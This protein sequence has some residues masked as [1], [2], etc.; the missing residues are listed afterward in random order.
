ME[1]ST[2]V[3]GKLF[4]FG[5]FEA[6]AAQ[7]A[8]TRNGAKI[9]IQEQ[10]FRLLLLLLARPNELIT[11]DELRQNLWAEGTYVDFD[12][13]LNVILKRLRAAI[14]DDPDNPR[15]I[16]TVPRQGYRFIAPVTVIDR[17]RETNAP[18]PMAANSPALAGVG[19][20]PQTQPATASGMP[21]SDRHS[22]PYVYVAMGLA[23]L[24]MISAGLLVWRYASTG[25]SASQS[26]LS[27]PQAVHM[28]KSVAVIGFHDLS[29]RAGNVWLGTALSEMLSTELAGGEKLRLVSGEDV[30][31][32][33]AA[34][35]WSQTDTLDR[36]TTARIG[37]ALNT[38]V[39]V[40]GSYVTIGSGDNEQLRLD[41]SMQDAKTGEIIGEVADVGN[42]K[43][44][45]QLVSRV[46]A[47]VRG[48]LGIGPLQN[49]DEAGVLAS[50]PVDPE[51]ARLYALGIEKL[52]QFDALAACDLLQQAADADPK[53]P[54]VHAMLA[55]AWALLGYEQKRRDEAK[56]ALDLSTDLP[57]PERMLVQGEYY[58]S[59][60]NQE[61]AASVYHALFE[62]FPDNLEYG[63]RL[64]AVQ[65]TLGH[66]S[67]A[68]EVIR[69]LR[70]LP[71]PSSD[72]PRIDLAETHA[73]E[74]NKPAE[75]VLIR[76]AMRK[77]QARGHRMLYALAR[78]EECMNL[79]YGGDA[80]AAEPSCEEAYNI[81]IS[82]GNRLDA[83]DAI[84]LMADKTG[85]A[86]HYEEAIATYQRAL[87][88]IEGLGEHHKTG[89][90]ENNMAIAYANEGK[91][92][93]SEQLYRQAKSDFEQAGDRPL[94]AV[95]MGNIADIL[96]LR[97]NLPAAAKLY[98]QTLDFMA[99][100]DHGEPGYVLMR[101]ADLQ[102]TQGN[103]RDAHRLAQQA[104][105]SLRP[106]E[107]A[108]QSQAD[109]MVELGSALE[110][111]GD[112]Q[113]AKEQ[114]EQTAVMRQ[115]FGASLL[116]E[117]SHVE[118]AGVRI[119]EGH[120]DDAEPLLR[121]AL[122]V[123]EKEKSDPD[124]SS[125]YTLLSRVLLEQGKLDDARSAAKKGAQLSLSSADPALRLPAEIQEA[126]VESASGDPGQVAAARQTL[127]AVIA[128]A[129]KLGYYN[130]ECE[131]R[132][133]LGELEL[134]ANPSIGHRQLTTLASETHERGLELLA[135]QAQSAIASGA[136]VARN[137]T[138]P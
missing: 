56:K 75:L 41:V 76:S 8:L 74:N 43:D 102:L 134:K 115:K 60:G 44:M 61:Q 99:T 125:A 4:R 54:L 96:Y 104:I 110:A 42:T 114:F 137:R 35:P 98:Q 78:K 97:G 108:F 112:L 136:A 36:S 101:L 105:D 5:V 34:S 64:A 126:R 77:A 3:P 119:E 124:S 129:A 37:E 130:V 19:L 133:A 118:L 29:G 65:T 1:R 68:S 15:F 33:R 71:L 53:F 9:K 58:E 131:A 48:I 127:H 91:L 120:P 27:S 117:E 32:L 24:V 132:L 38:D 7:G 88:V 80:A 69:R 95:T 47:R 81:F 87:N 20:V 111:E 79:L 85:S 46:G 10:P 23:A 45:F 14:N 93:R 51:A 123:F 128:T 107:N 13:S 12:G 62:L 106:A 59:I 100:V 49:A 113:G 103:V 11:R 94:V 72:D 39:L 2:E 109:A 6:D 92:D 31:N 57:R 50:L 40:L 63:L 83:A 55:R 67:Q 70:Q 135:H 25:A 90:I 138:T 21:I 17:V 52:R 26:F 116:V 28:R 122:A 22:R 18:S 82:A 86:G 66:G 89:A 84:R 16:Q 121:A 73:M 30:A